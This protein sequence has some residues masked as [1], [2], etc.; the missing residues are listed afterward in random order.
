MCWK[1]ARHSPYE[2][3]SWRGPLGF[4][5]QPGWLTGA[6]GRC[7]GGGPACAARWAAWP[8]RVGGGWRRRSGPGGSTST[9]AA[10]PAR[11]PPPGPGSSRTPRT[12]PERPCGSG[13]ASGPPCPGAAGTLRRSCPP[14]SKLSCKQDDLISP[15]SSYITQKAALVTNWLIQKL[16][17]ILTARGYSTV[18]W[19]NSQTMTGA[20]PWPILG[21]P[22]DQIWKSAPFLS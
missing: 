15:N 19:P 21:P 9:P 4:L 22:F 18:V 20:I 3:W 7:E 6:A 8:A 5:E 17:V 14:F 11:A 1:Q 2:R 16:W 12:T 10:S 13:G